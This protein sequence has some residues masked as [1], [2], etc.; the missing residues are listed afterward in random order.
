MST[1]HAAVIYT[2]LSRARHGQ[3][4]TE[5]QEQESQALAA[6]LG[7]PVREVYAEAP[8]TSGYAAVRRPEFDRM[9]R[10]LRPGDVIIA[11]ALDRLGRRGMEETGRLLRE[12]EERGARIVTVSDRT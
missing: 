1:T 10:E 3:T 11:W 5:R 7:V 12:V 4:S 6:R 9:L 2:R 8:G